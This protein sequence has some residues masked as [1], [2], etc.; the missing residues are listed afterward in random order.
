MYWW[1]CYQFGD[2]RRIAFLD[3]SY[4]PLF[5]GE[6]PIHLTLFYREREVRIIYAMIG[7]CVLL[8]YLLCLGIGLVNRTANFKS[9]L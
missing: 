7:E 2:L 9:I 8:S 5:I 1:S 4:S 3:I 6:P